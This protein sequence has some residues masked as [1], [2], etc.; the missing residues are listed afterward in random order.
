MSLRVIDVTKS[1]NALMF[2]DI[3]TE[4][5]IGITLAY[6]NIFYEVSLYKM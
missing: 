4:S 3:Q 2:Y 6:K 1:S 5:E